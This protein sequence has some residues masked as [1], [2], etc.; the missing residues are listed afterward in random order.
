MAGP[1]RA[2]SVNPPRVRGMAPFAAYLL[3]DANPLPFLSRAQSHAG[4]LFTLDLGLRRTLFLGYPARATHVLQRHADTYVKRVTVKT[5]LAA[6]IAQDGSTHTM[7]VDPRQMRQAMQPHLRGDAPADL[8]DL[9]GAALARLERDWDQLDAWSQPLD[10][11]RVVGLLAADL[12][13]ARLGARPERVEDTA[14]YVDAVGHAL[15]HARGRTLRNLAVARL[16]LAPHRQ[17]TA[18]DR[19]IEATIDRI[20]AAGRAPRDHET[21]LFSA[22]TAGMGAAA[23]HPAAVRDEVIRLLTAGHETV[24]A[25]A[26]WAMGLLLTHPAHHDAVRDEVDGFHDRTLTPTDLPRLPMTDA[27]VREALRLYPSAW[28][29]TRTAGA[30]DVIDGYPVASGASV[31]LSVYHMHRPGVLG[32]GRPVSARAFPGEPGGTRP[33]R[34]GVAALRQGTAQLCGRGHGDEVAHAHGGDVGAALH[35]HATRHNQT[36]QRA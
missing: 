23:Q 1:S 5:P 16:G 12:M 14:A 33:Q 27:V 20:V 13:L 7:S 32:R 34:R 35:A 6:L 17:Q 10:L 31:L 19:V 11:N 26:T 24:A 30:D 18:D 22:L 4:E 29:I 21:T 9:L 25:G 3:R 8:S 36:G 28:R 15:H 2:A